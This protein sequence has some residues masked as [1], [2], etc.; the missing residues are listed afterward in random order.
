MMP[1]FVINQCSHHNKLLLSILE[2]STLND[3]FQTSH[4]L[5]STSTC[6]TS[7]LT[8][9][10]LISTTASPTPTPLSMPSDVNLTMWVY[11]SSTIGAVIIIT[12]TLIL[13]FCISLCYKRN[14]CCQHSQGKFGSF[15][16]IQKEITVY[17]VVAVITVCPC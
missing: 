16:F 12:V 15:C 13:I 14:K 17:V 3:Y 7:L 10:L 6:C 1:E 5:A 8:S 2:N 4:E 9:S 11:I